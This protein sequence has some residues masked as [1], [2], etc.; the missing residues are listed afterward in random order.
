LK[1]ERAFQIS[2]DQECRVP[3]VLEKVPQVLGRKGGSVDAGEEDNARP[4][5]DG[6]G[7]WKGKRCKKERMCV[8][9]GTGTRQKPLPG[10][11]GETK[12]GGGEKSG[13]K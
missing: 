2:R 7:E 12:E 6:R 13:L 9:E 10:G 1:Q 11:G 4:F 3:K 5:V 8:G